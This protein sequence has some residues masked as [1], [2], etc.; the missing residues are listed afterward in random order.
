MTNDA[1]SPALIA[2]FVVAFVG[3][4][5]LVGLLLSEL[6]GWASLARRYPGGPRPEGVRLRGQV[7]GMG[8]VGEKGVTTLVPTA[9][10]LY[11]YSHPLFRF[12]RPPV[13]VPWSE[14]RYAGELGFLF[15]R[16]IGLDLGPVTRM[17][18]KRDAYQA[19]APYLEM[20]V[21]GRDARSIA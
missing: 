10:G 21:G 3:L 1:P 7:V 2:L 8:A 4:W 20:R 12:R 14:I 11:L 15:W 5:L 13:L 19:L 9:A 18:V 16:S 6:S 17:R